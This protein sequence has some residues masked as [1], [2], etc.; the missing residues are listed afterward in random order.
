MA[1]GQERV[2]G[3]RRE[4]RGCGRTLLLGF[5]GQLAGRR[6]GLG[7]AHPVTISL[8]RSICRGEPH[9]LVLPAL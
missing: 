5:L 2:I 7:G 8:G 4:R 6:S 3:D 1:V 9:F